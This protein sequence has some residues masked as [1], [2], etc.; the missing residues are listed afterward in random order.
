MTNDTAIL[1]FSRTVASEATHKPVLAPLKA[2]KKLYA[3][4]IAHSHLALNESGLPYFIFD[5]HQQSGNSFAQKLYGGIQSVFLKGYANVIVVGND[6]PGLNA[7]SI[8]NAACSLKTNDLVLGPSKNGGVYL[9]GIT[10][11][12]FATV[13]LENIQWQTSSVFEELKSITAPYLCS[14]LP[15]LADINTKNDLV[16]I[17]KYF[18]Q[19]HKFVAFLISLVASLSA[20]KKYF[21]Y[22]ILG[23]HRF[24]FA[25]IRPPPSFSF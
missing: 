8:T 13:H 25:G 10:Q 15:V 18:G 11:A 19:F 12:A 20:N 6:C 7:G 2:N 24:V 9:I 1:F 21:L 14:Y 22:N 3:A 5:E 23:C 16:E 4:F 17:K